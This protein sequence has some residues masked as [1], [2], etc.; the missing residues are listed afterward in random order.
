MKNK[1]K[2][3]T[4]LEQFQNRNIVETWSKLISLTLNYD[5]SLSWLGTDTS[6]FLGSIPILGLLQY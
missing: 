4:L 3:T 1:T 2:N 6:I 5:R